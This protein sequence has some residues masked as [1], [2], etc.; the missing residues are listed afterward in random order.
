LSGTIDYQESKSSGRNVVAYGV[1]PELDALKSTYGLLQGRL[2]DICQEHK[3]RLTSEAHDDIV[4][5]IFHPQKG[6]LLVASSL[7]QDH[8]GDGLSNYHTMDDEFD[9][10]SWKEVLEE[11]GLVYFKTPGL[12]DVDMEFGDLAGQI[13][14]T[15]KR[16]ASR[17]FGFPALC[18]VYL[19]FANVH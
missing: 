18:Q 13:I 15:S 6:Y 5:C 2:E 4:G 19:G 16:M 1:N 9:F 7:I 3:T 11:D 10:S 12:D 17:S 8:N 14:G